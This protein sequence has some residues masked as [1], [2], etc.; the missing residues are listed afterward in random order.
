MSFLLRINNIIFIVSLCSTDVCFFM[1]DLIDVAS[2]LSLGPILNNQ[3][4]NGQV[5]AHL[6]IGQV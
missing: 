4:T 2:L 6:T 3:R 5:N 1:L